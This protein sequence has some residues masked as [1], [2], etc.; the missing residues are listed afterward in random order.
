MRFSKAIFIVA[1]LMLAGNLAAFRPAPPPG[2]PSF[3]IP[4][5]ARVRQVFID[6]AVFDTTAQVVFIA[7]LNC[8][9]ED[10]TLM[11]RWP[12]DSATLIAFHYMDTL[13]DRY[14][15]H[16]GEPLRLNCPGGNINLRITY[17]IPVRR[18]LTGPPGEWSY[19]LLFS[20]YPPFVDS[21]G[22]PVK[23]EAWKVR[24]VFPAGMEPR[25]CREILTSTEMANGLVR[26][27]LSPK[28][29]PNSRCDFRLEE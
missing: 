15:L 13:E 27:S 21:S 16:G 26:W 17:E 12:L 9:G 6:A 14:S 18:A 20:L 4:E 25:S 10:L 7:S 22:N 3:Q 1:M 23:P 28:E 29:F 8:G 5:K 11:P 2:T 19:G 24:F